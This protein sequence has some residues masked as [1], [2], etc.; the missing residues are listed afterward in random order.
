[1]KDEIIELLKEKRYDELIRLYSIN[2]RVLNLLISFTYDR[3][4]IISYL[5]IDAIGILSKEIART[6]PEVIRNLIG[7][8]LWMIR[9]E[10]GGI[11]WSSPEILG[12]I[13]RNNIEL[14][15]DVA[16]VIAS[17]L[18]EDMLSA[19]VLKAIGRI[20]EVNPEP[21]GHTVHN[22]IPYLCNSDHKLRG[23]A[24]WALG[25]LGNQ[26]VISELEKLKDDSSIIEFYESGKIRESTIGH[27]AMESIKR[28]LNSS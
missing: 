25:R 21:V 2:N 22:I 6:K 28:L 20:G 17:F 15:S 9:D 27:I 5:A 10:S 8:L 4:S 24:A 11:G 18:D 23:L 19:S 7:R 26:D 12:E 1:L 16:P 14:F 13:V 3:K